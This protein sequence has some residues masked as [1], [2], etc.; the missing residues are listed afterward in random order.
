MKKEFKVE[1]E[2]F[3]DGDIQNY[4]KKMVALALQSL[5]GVASLMVSASVISSDIEAGMFELALG[6]GLTSIGVGGMISNYK[7]HKDYQEYINRKGK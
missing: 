3:K 4:G 7:Y 1:E 2:K 5:V 6:A